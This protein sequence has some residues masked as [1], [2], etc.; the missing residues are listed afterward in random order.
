MSGVGWYGDLG[1]F[2]VMPT[3]GPLKTFKGTEDEPERGYRSR[4]SHDR[5]CARIDRY[6]FGRW[7][8]GKESDMLSLQLSTVSYYLGILIQ[9]VVYGVVIG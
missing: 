3:V 1:N 2:L 6:A 5:E 8:F 9:T 7:K 4:F